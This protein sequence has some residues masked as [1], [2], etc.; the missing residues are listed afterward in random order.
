MILKIAGADAM[1]KVPQ[2]FVFCGTGE[3][4][5]GESHKKKNLPARDAMGKLSEQA[6]LYIV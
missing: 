5:N 4:H 6:Q 2:K 3:S 1:G